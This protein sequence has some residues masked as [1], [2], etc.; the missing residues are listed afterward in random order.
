[1]PKVK[2]DLW[3]SSLGRSYWSLINI[4]KH[5]FL[6]NPIELKFHVK[7]PN[8]KLDKMYTK[9]LGQMTKMTTLPIYGK[10]LLKSSPEPE[11]QWPWDL[12]CSVGDVGPSKFVQMMIFC[13]SGPMYKAKIKIMLVCC[14]PTDGRFSVRPNIFFDFQK[15]K[16]KIPDPALSGK[17]RILTFPY[18]PVLFVHVTY[19]TM[20]AI[21][22]SLPL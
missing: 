17:V 9:Y 5:S 12:V 1:M 7:T 21:W 6:T 20:C 18:I 11:G 2:V 4:L 3:H 13:L 16:K 22:I 15:K 19:L 14:L 8:D 10:N